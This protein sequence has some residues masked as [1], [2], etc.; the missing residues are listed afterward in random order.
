[1]SK[2]GRAS[3]S[4][5]IPSRECAYLPRSKKKKRMRKKKTKKSV[6]LALSAADSNQTSHCTSDFRRIW[7]RVCT[8]VQRRP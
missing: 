5:T 3:T 4:L 8:S 1:M 2:E 7:S 6:I